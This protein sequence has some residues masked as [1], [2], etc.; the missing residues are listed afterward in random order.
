MLANQTVYNLIR[1]QTKI[2]D[3]KKSAPRPEHGTMEK[4]IRNILGPLVEKYFAGRLYTEQEIE[5][6]VVLDNC[7]FDQAELL[8]AREEAIQK[9][10]EQIDWEKEVD[11]FSSSIDGSVEAE[12]RK[13]LLEPDRFECVID[14]HWQEVNSVGCKDRPTYT[15]IRN[16]LGDTHKV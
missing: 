9:M 8:D 12:I 14:L 6:E 2:N 1:S 4:H 5:A 10:V 3:I 16:R 13:N 7:F 11:S 15:S